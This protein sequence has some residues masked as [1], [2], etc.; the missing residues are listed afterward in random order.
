MK[1]VYEVMSL[2]IKVLLGKGNYFNESIV[3]RKKT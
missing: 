1:G 3:V 2:I